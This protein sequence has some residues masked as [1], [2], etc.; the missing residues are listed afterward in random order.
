MKENSKYNDYRFNG[1]IQVDENQPW[2][3]FASNKPWDDS[4]IPW[5]VENKV[6]RE[7]LVKLS[8]GEKTFE[9]LYNTI[10]FSPKPL[11]IEK[12]EYKTNV[13]YQWSKQTIENHLLN[14][15]W[16][17]MIK[18]VNNKYSLTFP[19]YKIEDITNLNAYIDNLAQNWS[20]IIKEA[21]KEIEK[22]N[23][24][25]NDKN[26]IYGLL[27]EKSIEKLYELLKKEKI[28][29]VINNLKLLWAEQLRKIKFE[30][31]VEK[32]F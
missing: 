30:E 7:I 18:R 14:L 29:P 26:T 22:V 21:K 1:R 20:S 15:E 12:T 4:E 17:D 23:P 3:D 5:L 19:I 11:L 16:N 9:E 31:W 25:Q 32:N 13:S 10:N 28:L 2:F 6:R 8:E 27:I 24:Q